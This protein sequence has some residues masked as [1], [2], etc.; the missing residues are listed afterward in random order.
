MNILALSSGSRN[1][2]VRSFKQELGNK[3]KIICTD[4]SPLAPSLYEADN[5][6]IVPRI[7]DPEYLNVILEICKKER[8]DGLFSLIDPELSLLSKNKELFEKNNIKLFLSGYKQVEM[9]FDKFKFYEFC[10]GNGFYT[11]KT[12]FG[13]ENIRKAIDKKELR[14]P[15]F[16]KPRKGSCSM[17]IQ[18]VE[19]INDLAYILDHNHDLIVQEYMDG[20]EFGCDVYVDV[21]SKKVVSIFLKEKILMRAGETDK[22]KSVKNEKL[23]Q[24]IIQFVETAGFIG[25]IDIDIFEKN[26]RYY[27]SE[28]NPRF[29]GGYPHA[30]FCGCNFPQYM[31]HNLLNRE[32]DVVIGDYKESIYMMKYLDM[33][34]LD[35]SF[36]E[37]L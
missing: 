32:N 35:E 5:F 16:V 12:Y 3:G 15:V 8:I 10:I 14:F 19:C 33:Q 4:C 31:I 17:G 37:G 2:L 22:S 29:G 23:F 18:K 28:V 27:F 36:G 21:I 9:C 7:D 25:Q 24:E 1:V 13:I 30:Y 34:I 26:G 6:Y 11:V 20:K